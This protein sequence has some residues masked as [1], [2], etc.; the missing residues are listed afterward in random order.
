VARLSERNASVTNIYVGNLSFK[1]TEDDLRQAFAQYGE[2][3]SVSI[4]KDRE[5]G[6]SRGF[7]FVEMNDAT[8]ANEA[9][10]KLNETEI[11]GRNVTVNEAR[12]RTDR[13]RKAG[14]PPRD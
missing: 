8:Q 1:A 6:R 12:P 10:Q 2:V 13:P 11:A 5:S 9:I 7:A 14:G 3:S 4:V